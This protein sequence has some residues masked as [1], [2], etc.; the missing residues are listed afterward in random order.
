[1]DEIENFTPWSSLSV[2]RSHGREGRGRGD[3]DNTAV[4]GHRKTG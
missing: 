1:M 4:N 2:G 3:A